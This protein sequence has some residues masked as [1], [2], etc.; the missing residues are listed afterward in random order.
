MKI[1]CKQSKEMAVKRKTDGILTDVI[2]S[3]LYENNKEAGISINVNNST[4]VIFK[5]TK[6]LFNTKLDADFWEEMLWQCGNRKKINNLEAAEL[7]SIV[8]ELIKE[9]NTGINQYYIDYKLY[10]F[11]IIRRF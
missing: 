4:E 6:E 8:D 3:Y 2:V 10:H 9:V 7:S 5:D 1:I 11:E